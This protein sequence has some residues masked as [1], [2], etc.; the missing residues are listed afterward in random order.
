MK[1]FVICLLGLTILTVGVEA[2]SYVRSSSRS[3]TRSSTKSSR[4]SSSSY[5]SSTRTKSS[6]SSIR[7]KTTSTHKTSVS[8]S[9]S[10]KPASKSN[11]K[12]NV[13]K[14]NIFSP[15]NSSVSRSR[16]R[17]SYQSTA[18]KSSSSYVDTSPRVEY[19]NSG[20]GLGLFDY[21]MIN[22]I[23]KS[24]N[25]DMTKYNPQTSINSNTSART[26][27]LDKLSNDELQKIL[28]AVNATI[29]MVDDSERAVLERL[30][31]RIIEEQRKRANDVAAPR[32]ENVG[33]KKI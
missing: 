26:E 6:I 19:V 13:V 20:G 12:T 11:V 30:R 17:E 29:H 5:K 3:S 24:N 33:V 8:S 4:K 15:S 21:F 1:K 16:S 14:S 9:Y 7:P 27:K 28:A 10:T 23:V 2:K 22:H 18:N 31:L 25:N 32:V